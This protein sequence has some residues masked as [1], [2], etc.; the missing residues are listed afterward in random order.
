MLG[1]ARKALA[2]HDGREG[3]EFGEI[4]S[5]H[6][7]NISKDPYSII[8]HYLRN[9]SPPSSR[10]NDGGIDEP[11]PESSGTGGGLF[12]GGPFRW[13]RCRTL[14]HARCCCDGRRAHL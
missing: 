2:I 7:A 6:Y 4:R 13:R 14:L 9:A 1:G 11:A 5:A 12:R 3:P 8:G 10:S